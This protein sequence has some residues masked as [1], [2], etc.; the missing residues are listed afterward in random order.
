[1]RRRD[2]QLVSG[3][4]FESPNEYVDYAGSKEGIDTITISLAMKLGPHE[5][6]VNVIRVADIAEYNPSLDQ[7]QHTAQVAARL[8]HRLL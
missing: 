4:R 3:C 8:A 5:I 7:D 6:R 2:H 1:M